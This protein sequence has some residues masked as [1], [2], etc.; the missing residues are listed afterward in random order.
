MDASR[1][2]TAPRYTVQDIDSSQ[3]LMRIEWIC[4]LKWKKKSQNIY[5]NIAE[6]YTMQVRKYLLK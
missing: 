6:K 5:G 4:E 1:K 3:I 2:E